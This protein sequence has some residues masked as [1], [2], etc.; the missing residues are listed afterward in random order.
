MLFFTLHFSDFL[1]STS[2]QSFSDLC[3]EPDEFNLFLCVENKNQ[4]DATEWFIALIICSTCFGHFYA[5]HQE[6]EIICVSLPSMMCSAWLLVVGGQVQSSRL[7]VQYKGCCST[8][9]QQHPS[10]L[11]PNCPKHVE[12]IISAINHS[13]ASSRFFFST[14]MQRCTDKHISSSIYSSLSYFFKIYLTFPMYTQAFKVVSFLSKSKYFPQQFIPKIRLKNFV[15]QSVR[16]AS[17]THFSKG[18]L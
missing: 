16:H 5:H 18:K 8:A 1:F 13:V 2:R 12:H 14:H 7:C 10:S 11:I 9:V 6:F 3:P 17:H 4:L 15:P